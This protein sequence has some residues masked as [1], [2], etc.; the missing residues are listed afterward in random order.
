MAKTKSSDVVK[1]ITWESVRQELNCKRTDQGVIDYDGV[2]RTKLAKLANHTGRAAILYA[3]DFLNGEK[4]KNAP[5][6]MSI[7]PDDMRVVCSPKTGPGG[8]RVSEALRGQE[9][10]HEATHG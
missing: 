5:N 9:T 6:A 4:T 2:R 1:S 3:T 8:M 7:N 10:N